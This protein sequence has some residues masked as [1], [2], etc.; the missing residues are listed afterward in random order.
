MENQHSR[1]GFLG[2]HHSFHCKN[3]CSADIINPFQQLIEPVERSGG[4]AFIGSAP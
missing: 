3:S 1:G 4:R 2:S